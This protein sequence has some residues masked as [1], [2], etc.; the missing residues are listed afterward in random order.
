MIKV[1]MCNYTTSTTALRSWC[2]SDSLL[3]SSSTAGVSAQ[4][5]SECRS[6]PS[7]ISV[8]L[9]YAVTKNNVKLHPPFAHTLVASLTPKRELDGRHM[10]VTFWSCW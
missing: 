5:P 6:Q 3:D 9:R 4:V 2:F 10:L 8:E 7:S 1:S